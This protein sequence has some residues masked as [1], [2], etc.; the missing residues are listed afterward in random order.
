MRLAEKH[1]VYELHSLVTPTF[2]FIE[3]FQK[4]KIHECENN[5]LYQKLL[6][7][8]QENW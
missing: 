6:K 7:E 8:N 3:I 5:I 1:N 2:M 4:N